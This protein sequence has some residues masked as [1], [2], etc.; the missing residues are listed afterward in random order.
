MKRAGLST[1][2]QHQD[3]Q[4]TELALDACFEVT[5]GLVFPEAT[6]KHHY[7]GGPYLTGPMVYIKTYIFNHFY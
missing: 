6:G 3:A 1:T 2:V 7:Y 5:G 4:D